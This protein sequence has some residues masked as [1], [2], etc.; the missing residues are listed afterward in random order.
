MFGE[1]EPDTGDFKKRRRQDIA[2]H[3]KWPRIERNER[4]GALSLFRASRI[5]EIW[6]ALRE[7]E[8]SR[9]RLD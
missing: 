1:K 2:T 7:T 3:R 8:N 6:V 9:W 4:P 5:R